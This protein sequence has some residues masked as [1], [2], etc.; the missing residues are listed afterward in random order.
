MVFSVSLPLAEG[1][2]QTGSHRTAAGIPCADKQN[3]L[4]G[5]F[6]FL[7]VRINFRKGRSTAQT[8]HDRQTDAIR[9]QY[10]TEKNGNMVIVRLTK[11]LE[12]QMCHFLRRFPAASP[13]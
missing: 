12:Q 4:H 8:V 11:Q 7:N 5:L 13:L 3:R 6:F 2:E 10:F 9:G 1:V